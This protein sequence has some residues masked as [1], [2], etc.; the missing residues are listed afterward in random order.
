ML[1]QTEQILQQITEYFNSLSI[2]A[3]KLAFPNYRTGIYEYKDV[4]KWRVFPKFVY[5]ISHPFLTG[6]TTSLVFY[7]VWLV[8]YL[9]QYL[10]L[11]L[12]VSFLYPIL[13]NFRPF[14]PPTNGVSWFFL[15]SSLIAGIPVSIISYMWWIDTLADKK[16]PWWVKLILLACTGSLLFYLVNTAQS[17]SS[18]YLTWKSPEEV[19]SII[20]SFLFL[21][22]PSCS[23]FVAL[24]F[25][26]L[27]AILIFLK[28]L[29]GGVRS[30]HEA[31]PI[32]TILDL[33]TQEIQS[34]QSEGTSWKL[35]DLPKTEIVVLHQWAEANRE[36]SEKRTIPAFLLA[37]LISLLFTSDLLRQSFDHFLSTLYTN[38]TTYYNSKSVFSL[39]FEVSF[40]A[41]VIFPIIALLLI[42]ILKNLLAL[43]RNIV[44]QN[45]IIE[46]CI[47][48]EYAC[49]KVEKKKVKK[50]WLQRI[51]NFWKSITTNQ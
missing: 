26:F 6:N 17:V 39:P 21:L 13:F 18:S 24:F 37:A 10:A 14:F 51:I 41:L 43:F 20:F 2:C 16:N 1:N 29:F 47:V 3:E 49:E 40:A 11:I 46:T 32:D 23:Y 4:S 9:I 31:R 7:I 45:L 27:L 28:T 34:T 19:V 42:V 44:A 50:N 15:V 22:I 30:I 8:L 5:N 25:D 48:V 36:N 12:G 38:V 35:I 33:A